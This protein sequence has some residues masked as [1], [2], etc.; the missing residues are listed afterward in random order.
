MLYI[1]IIVEILLVYLLILDLF[2]QETN[3]KFKEET[4]ESQR[5][6]T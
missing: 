2:I 4:N 6:S 1:F 3:K 5:L